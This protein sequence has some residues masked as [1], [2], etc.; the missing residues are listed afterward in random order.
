MYVQSQ[1]NPINYVLNYS[2]I[3][4]ENE[5]TWNIYSWRHRCTMLCQCFSTVH[6][7]TVIP[8]EPIDPTI[9]KTM[10]YWV[11]DNENGI[12]YQKNKSICLL[13]L[14][15]FLSIDL[16]LLMVSPCRICPP[17]VWL[18]ITIISSHYYQFD[19]NLNRNDIYLFNSYTFINNKRLQLLSS[20]WKG[21]TGY[22]GEKELLWDVLWV[23][24]NP[25]RDDEMF[26]KMQTDVDGG[27]IIFLLYF[28]G[29]NREEMS[30][31]FNRFLFNYMEGLTRILLQ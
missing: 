11:N 31:N 17:S 16:L 25:N 28:L 20:G 10:A 30:S 15:K 2:Q 21:R 19:S 9:T 18:R 12:R 1:F 22:N 14:L 6:K 24:P 13:L 3:I 4:I 8:I 23:K 26:D 7:D 5:I 27:Q 29:N